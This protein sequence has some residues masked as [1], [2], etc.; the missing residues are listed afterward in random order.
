MPKAA[1]LRIIVDSFHLA[2]N[3]D[4]NNSKLRRAS[5][6]EYDAAVDGAEV[7]GRRAAA[8]TSGSNVTD[9]KA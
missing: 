5:R 2:V 4:R 7:N 6:A 1:S 3:P 9:V 8:V